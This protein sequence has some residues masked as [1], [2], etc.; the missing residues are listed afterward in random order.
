MKIRTKLVLLMSILSAII[1]AQFSNTIISNIA[2]KNNVSEVTQQVRLAEFLT[3]FV[4]VLQVERGV[5]VG[6]IVSGA[7]Q[8]QDA[9]I[10][11]RQKVDQAFA[12][13]NAQITVMS[14]MSFTSQQTEALA[15]VKGFAQDLSSMRSKVDGKTIKATDWV[16]HVTLSIS[17]MMQTL[18]IAT[19][20]NDVGTSLRSLHLLTE[21][22]ELAG[23]ERA[24]GNGTI[25]AKA[26]LSDE[27][28]IQFIRLDGAQ[29]TK[30]EAL[31]RAVSGKPVEQLK[32]VR[33]ADFSN[34]IR[35]MRS[36][37]IERYMS[38]SPITL[39]ASQW[40]AKTTK[41][42]NEL[43][44][45]GVTLIAQ[46]QAEIEKHNN[47]ATQSVLLSAIFGL[48]LVIGLVLVYLLVVQRGIRKPL[49]E[50][51]NQL[52]N[53]VNTNSFS[54]RINNQ[55]GDEIGDVSRALN[56]LLASFNEAITETNYVVSA[57]AVGDLSKRI[58]GN[59]VGDLEVLKQG[60]NNSANNIAKVMTE[61]SGAMTALQAGNFN[62]PLN[63]NAQGQYGEMLT[64]ASSA[65]ISFSQ[66]IGEIVEVMHQMSEGDFNSRVRV[67]AHGDLLTMKDN[68]NTSMSAI[69]Q[70]I[71]AI[72]EV[73]AAQAM[74]D[75]TKELP[76]GT[77]KGQLHDLKNAIN[78]S[79]AKVKESVIQAVQ[80][81]NIVSEA[82]AQVSQGSSDL[83]GRVQ[84]QAAALEQT[85]STMNE[86]AAAVQANTA[87]ARKVA[88]LAHQVQNQSNTGVAV[89]QQTIEAMQSIRES[90]HKISDIV[91]IIDGIAFQT[92]L[93][94]LN[95][96]VEAARAG[97]H[98][99]G[100]AVVASE[101][102]ALAG[103]SADA[104]KDIK[105]LI[106]DS[107]N[108]I[109]AGTQLADKSGDMLNGI[110]ASV[111]QVAS[112][113]E[114]IANASNE[115]STGI[116]QVHRAMADI[117]KVT[118]EN[119]ALVEETTAAAESLSSEANNLRNNMAFFKT[120]QIAGVRATPH[121]APR[122]KVKA[123]VKK[124]M[125]LPAPKK[126]SS[127]EWGEF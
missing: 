1:L 65:M 55:S 93:L 95:A 98:G 39:E 44:D 6:V 88:N 22:K 50:M 125:G 30:F 97:E 23:Q 33:S 99:R 49:E 110:T 120:G 100:F 74:G 56:Q 64:N 115:Q 105:G 9:M 16:D 14:G 84:E 127:Q 53:I 11:A 42:I 13:L 80:A 108:R 116:N 24:I 122:S 82:S 31:E 7:L 29:K 51:T 73:V 12:P 35:Q 38:E 70:A 59:Y 21:A 32:A 86:M 3:Q 103:K 25:I 47:H 57:I 109:E 96:A 4:H 63:T 20:L 104:A 26:F 61:L 41:R 54:I 119:A 75:L 60:V 113:I 17:K 123:P 28:M 126:P 52:I 36:I 46:A 118:Q 89:M 19:T 94:A 121:S 18:M 71:N 78:Y 114:E 58:N 43:N 117:D 40:F 48:V 68:I 92:N 85:S 81:S 124:Q 107:V 77:F 79:S 2:V 8:G 37:M 111:E 67:A 102:R 15:V 69:A 101:V 76:S 5:T 10:A 87:N 106:S 112:M 27:R 72:S 45:V 91:T 83:S 90:S 62:K 34:D 66:V